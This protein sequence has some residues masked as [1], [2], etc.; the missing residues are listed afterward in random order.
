MTQLPLVMLHSYK[1][2]WFKHSIVLNGP[3]YRIA[4]LFLSFVRRWS[5]NGSTTSIIVH[6]VFSI[7]FLFL[8]FFFFFFL[9]ISLKSSLTYRH[10]F[11]KLYQKSQDVNLLATAVI[12]RVTWY[13]ETTIGAAVASTTYL[14]NSNVKKKWNWLHTYIHTNIQTQLC[15][16]L[17]ALCQTT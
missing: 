8:S 16:F 14:C 5:M 15:W 7:S 1:D 3:S 2:P 6:D 10:P 9:F 11:D 17:S 13:T 12:Q 4:R